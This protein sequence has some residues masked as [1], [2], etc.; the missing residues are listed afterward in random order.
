MIAMVE[1]RS[2]FKQIRVLE[3]GVLLTLAVTVASQDK[4]VLKYGVAS[5]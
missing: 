2:C 3:E 4:L 5:F 1:K